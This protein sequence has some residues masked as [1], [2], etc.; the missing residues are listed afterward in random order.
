MFLMKS[1]QLLSLV[2]GPPVH[3]LDQPEESTGRS[4]HSGPPQGD[5]TVMAVWLSTSQFY[6]GIL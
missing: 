4:V 2:G 5:K 6:M 1:G 3:H